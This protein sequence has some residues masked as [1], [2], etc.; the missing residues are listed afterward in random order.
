MQTVQ[1]IVNLLL[2]ITFKLSKMKKI[3]ILLILVFACF[4]YTFSQAN[5][6]NQVLVYFKTGAQRV[7]PSNTT[8]NITSQNILNV[9]NTYSIPTSNIVPSFPSFNESDT[10]NAELGEISRQ[11]NRAKVFTIT[12][13]TLEQKITLLLP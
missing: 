4:M 5:L 6:Q 3:F 1:I 11:M 7:A 13:Q 12:V 8:S 2:I 9:L 10:I